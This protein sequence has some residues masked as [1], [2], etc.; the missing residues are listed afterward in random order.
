MKI[1]N[2]QFLVL[3]SGQNMNNIHLCGKLALWH[4]STLV[5][6]AEGEIQEIWQ[7]KKKKN[8]TPEGK[9]DLTV[10]ADNTLGLGLKCDLAV[11]GKPVL[12]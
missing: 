11:K 9:W 1:I 5:S 8:E 6:E 4:N 7:E 12:F 2:K 10:M 3:V